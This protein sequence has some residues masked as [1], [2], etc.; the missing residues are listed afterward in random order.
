MSPFHKS[1]KTK[2]GKLKEAL[3]KGIGIIDFLNTVQD[4]ERQS[5]GKWELIIFFGSFGV[6]GLVFRQ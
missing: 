5:Q 1:G 6:L 3:N 4:A 2:N